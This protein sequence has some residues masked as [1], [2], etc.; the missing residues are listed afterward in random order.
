MAMSPAFAQSAPSAP[1]VA[2][3]KTVAARPCDPATPETGQDGEL[4]FAG[5]QV[6]AMGGT[7]PKLT[8]AAKQPNLSNLYQKGIQG[9]VVFDLLIGK[10]GSIR[11]AVIKNSSSSPELDAIAT[12]LLT[13]SKFSPAADHDGKPVQVRAALP[14]YFWKDSMTDPKFFKK[15]CRDFLTDVGWRAEHFPEEKPEQYRGWLLAKGAMVI[16]SIRAA[17]GLSAV[18]QNRE[19][20]KTPAYSD[21]VDGCKAKPDKLFFDVLTGR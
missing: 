2:P 12:G 17:G 6:R 10:D 8:S 21:V 1:A 20:P 4:I 9:E 15:P 13:G 18:G 16:I 7:L 5:C 14:M 11:N 19:F 3:D